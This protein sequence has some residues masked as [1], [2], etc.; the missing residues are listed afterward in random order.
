M[1]EF[2][3]NLAVIIG[4]N[5]YQEQLGIKKL[6]AAR[7][8]AEKLDKI[9]YK[10][11]YEVDLLVDEQA[12]FDGITNFLTITLP[13]KIKT[14]GRVRLWLERRPQSI[15]EQE[16]LGC[17]SIA[18]SRCHHKLVRRSSWRANSDQRNEEQG[19]AKRHRATGEESFLDFP[20]L[21]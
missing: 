4:I 9:L 14:D 13:E 5:D 6:K 2:D 8:D 21:N 15:F 7:P 1:A 16:L 17:C 10:Q 19:R 3:R 12:T 18:S 11:G 20:E